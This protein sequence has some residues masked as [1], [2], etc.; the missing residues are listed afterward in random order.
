[1]MTNLIPE[2]GNTTDLIKEIA[3]SSMEQKTGASQISSA[4]NQLNEVIQRNTKFADDLSKY[5][6]DL[7]TESKE[8][9]ARVSFFDTDLNENK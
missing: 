2:I 6:G 5:S 8:L 7:E 3:A 9:K 1:M 4:I